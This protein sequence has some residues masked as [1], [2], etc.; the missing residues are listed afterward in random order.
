MY[1]EISSQRTIDD[2]IYICEKGIC[3]KNNCSFTVTQD[4][5]GNE[6]CKA[7]GSLCGNYSENI[8]LKKK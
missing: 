6:T 2:D 4:D 1:E 7:E 3:T 8:I 5:N